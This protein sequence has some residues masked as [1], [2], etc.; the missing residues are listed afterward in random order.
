MSI[1][2]LNLLWERCKGDRQGGNSK[3]GVGVSSRK[4]H[5]L[6]N[7]VRGRRK[8]QETDVRALRSVGCRE[9][10]FGT[11]RERCLAEKN[12]GNDAM[13]G[14]SQ[15][16]RRLLRGETIPQEE[17]VFIRRAYSLDSKGKGGRSRRAWRSG[18]RH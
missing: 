18:L 1:T 15:V 6:F 17:K 14:D 7:R 5:K 9:G 2:D 4:V 8:R 3:L 10:N 16:D 13:R 11:A 12:R